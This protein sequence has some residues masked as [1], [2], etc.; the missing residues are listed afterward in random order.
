VVAH[1]TTFAASTVYTAT[2]TLTAK[3][4][5]TLQGVKANFF[6]VNGATATNAA[7]SGVITAVFPKTGGTGTVTDPT[8]I[9]I[10]AIEGLTAPATGGTPVTTIRN[11]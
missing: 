3:E 10:S 7:N 11:C 2:I 5:Y 4:T 8:V 6:T 1:H 9:S